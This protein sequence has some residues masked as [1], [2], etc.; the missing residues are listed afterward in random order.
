MTERRIR[1]TR[2]ATRDLETIWTYGAEVWGARQATI[3][4]R[5]LRASVE[6][7]REMPEIA[8]ERP[9]FTPPLRI[10]PSAQHLIIYFADD[11]ALTVVRILSPRQNWQA[12]LG[13]Q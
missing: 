4:A 5:A 2:E 6:T 12:I 11:S 13:P 8:R 9:E 1:Y 10:H 3:Y 7:L